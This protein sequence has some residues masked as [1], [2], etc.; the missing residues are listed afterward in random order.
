MSE[1]IKIFNARG[2]K[3]VKKWGGAS[4]HWTVGLRHQ[5]SGRTMT[6]D[7]YMGTGHNGKRPTEY[8]VLTCM[9]SDAS[10]CAEYGYDLD[11][12]FTSLGYEKPSEARKA[13]TE[14]HAQTLRFAELCGV[15]PEGLDD[16]RI[17]HWGEDGMQ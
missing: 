11:E 2:P 12:W 15:D 10:L 16:Y 13:M 1:P 5:E 4:D 3:R 9:F 6:I 17:A 14:C 8:D 7:F